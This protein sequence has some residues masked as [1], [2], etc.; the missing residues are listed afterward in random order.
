MEKRRHRWVHPL[1]D[2]SAQIHQTKPAGRADNQGKQGGKAPELSEKVAQ[3]G[4]CKLLGGMSKPPPK[5]PLWTDMVQKYQPFAAATT[6]RAVKQYERGAFPNTGNTCFIHAAVLM[7][8]FKPGVLDRIQAIPLNFSK[9][10]GGR[11][12]CRY[13]ALWP[14]ERPT[15]MRR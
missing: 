14:K 8:A 15:H 1:G 5:Q 3:P 10:H 12:H 7:S 11:Q 9:A 6:P 4:T 2:K 13:T